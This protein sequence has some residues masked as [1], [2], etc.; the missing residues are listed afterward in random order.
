MSPYEKVLA[1]LKAAGSRRQ[2]NNWQCKA[3]DD[4]VPSLSVNLA[5]DGSGMVLMHC[6]AGCSL[7]EVTAAI[8]LTPADLF[9]NGHGQLALFPKSQYSP[10]GLDVIKKQPPSAHR[11]LQAAGALGRYVDRWGG[12]RKVE[13]TRQM[14]CV[15]LET[16]HRKA[17]VE[18]LGISNDSLRQDIRRWRKWGV[19]HACP[20]GLIAI[21]VRDSECCPFCKALLVD[22][23]HPQGAL[24]MDHTAHPL[25]LSM[26]HISRHELE[27]TTPGFFKELDRV[28]WENRFPEGDG[29]PASLNEKNGSSRAIGNMG[30]LELERKRR[31][32]LTRL[33]EWAEKERAADG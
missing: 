5:S 23:T 3:H 15:V 6:H 12:R 33:E 32:D 26:D 31:R 24:S 14:L 16:K 9:P 13:S 2:G 8:G 7:V 30:N 28:P 1:A 17:V 20:G 4:R 25:A 11:T 22:H 19:A 10:L 21:L 27:A 18:E 29:S